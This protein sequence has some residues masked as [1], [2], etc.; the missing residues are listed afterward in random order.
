MI[1]T[2]LKS[3]E[4]SPK[5]LVAHSYDTSSNTSSI[6]RKF[7]KRLVKKHPKALFVHHSARSLNQ[8]LQNA[9]CAVQEV[10]NALCTV[11][12]LFNFIEACSKRTSMG[13]KLENV[14]LTL[15][16]LAITDWN[17]RSMIIKAVNQTL[18]V[19]LTCLK[20]SAGE[21]IFIKKFKFIKNVVFEENQS[22]LT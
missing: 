16:K 13:K 17:S 6:Y 2:R 8:S 22:C 10:R 14:H 1:L 18:L 7:S 19:V 20:V 3:L 11:N 15:T 9:S 12:S 21:F 5:N 4:L